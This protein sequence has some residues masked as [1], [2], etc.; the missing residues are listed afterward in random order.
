MAER[1][2]SAA[3]AASQPKAGARVSRRHRWA[4][5][6]LAVVLL[7][8]V[9][10]RAFTGAG[11]PPPEAAKAP[12][13]LQT[14]A[15]S[16]LPG[17]VP[18]GEPTPGTAEEPEGGLLAALPYLT[19]GSFFALIGFALGYASKLVLKLALVLLALLFLALQGLV[20]AD[21]ATVDWGLAIEKLN[22][23]IFNVRGADTTREW[24]E[25]RVPSAGGFI[26]GYL[27]GL[28]RG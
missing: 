26:A 3:G 20:W 7:A 24:L 14:Q 9:V 2:E 4:F 5:W 8:S 16:F 18:T 10:L 28:R 17:L 21:I 15:D 19:E 27:L 22:T 25:A 11:T 1:S 6:L 23:L 12:L 13:G